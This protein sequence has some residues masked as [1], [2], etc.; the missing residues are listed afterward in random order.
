M[1]EQGLKDSQC[2]LF[3]HYKPGASEKAR[4]PARKWAQLDQF[5]IEI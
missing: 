2:M 4:H 5:N 3:A 1:Q